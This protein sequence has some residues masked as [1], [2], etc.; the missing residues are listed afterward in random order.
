VA[1]S[2]RWR[3][4]PVL[5]TVLSV[6][7]V[8]V[9]FALSVAAAVTR[10]AS[11]PPAWPDQPRALVGGRAGRVDARL[12]RRRPAVPA[13]SPPGRIAEDDHALPRPGPKRLKVAWRAGLT[14][15]LERRAR[16]DVAGDGARPRSPRRSPRRSFPWRPRLAVTTAKRV[17][18]PKGSGLHGHDR[19]RA[20]PPLADR[21]RLR[22]SALLHDVGKLSVHPTS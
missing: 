14:R 1:R 5:G 21:D 6:A 22:W 13:P 12:P 20:P 18:T 15:D 19:R 10:G 8:A 7:A 11:S 4:Y 3:S 9:P 2:D 16:S 17:V